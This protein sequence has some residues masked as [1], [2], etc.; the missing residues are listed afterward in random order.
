MA[1]VSVLS[2]K[3]GYGVTTSALA[4]A[5]TWPGEYGSVVAELDPLGGDIAAGYLGA[6]HD[7]RRGVIELLATDAARAGDLGHDL[8]AQVQPLPGSR[9]G[10]LRGFDSPVQARSVPWGELGAVLSSANVGDVIADLGALLPIEGQVKA[11]VDIAP[12]WLQSDAIVLVVRPTLPSVRRTGQVLQAVRE[13]LRSAGSNDD[14]LCLLLVGDGSYSAGEISRQLQV[15]A[16]GAIGE[17]PAA[18]ALS[19]GKQVRGLH[20]SSVLRDARSAGRHI[21]EL[22][23]RRAALRQGRTA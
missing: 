18:A 7:P 14:P 2:A 3:S 22:A 1:L 15:P 17:S 4:L 16:A 8:A 9:A 5:L 19:W 23:V 20:R 10:L 13:I 21:H 11:G 12:L 6:A